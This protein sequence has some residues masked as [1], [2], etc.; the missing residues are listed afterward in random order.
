[1]SVLWKCDIC[2][3]ETSINPQ[4]KPV[5]IDG[6]QAK[7]KRKY[8]NPQTNEVETIEVPLYED[9]EPRTYIIKVNV[10][11]ENVTRDVCKEC[12]EKEML[13]LIKPLWDKLENM[14]SN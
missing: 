7:G 14:E 12:L 6:V 3:K 5:M 9:L 2:G 4:V 8:Q 13:P 11:Q 1:M 10:G